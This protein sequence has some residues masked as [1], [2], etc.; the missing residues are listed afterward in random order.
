MDRYFKAFKTGKL[1]AGV[2]NHFERVVG[3]GTNA[4]KK[5]LALIASVG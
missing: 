5:D 1:E 4:Q 3:A 2:M